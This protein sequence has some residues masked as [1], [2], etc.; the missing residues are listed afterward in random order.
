MRLKPCAT[1]SP[2]ANTKTL[3]SAF[4]HAMQII[5]NRK[6][7]DVCIIGS[8]AGGSSTDGDEKLEWVAQPRLHWPQ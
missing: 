6:V 5:R 3:Y 2:T 1:W 4:G 7:Y 8:G